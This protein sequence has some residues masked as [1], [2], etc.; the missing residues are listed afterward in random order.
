[1]NS[2]PMGVPP[3][4]QSRLKTERSDHHRRVVLGN[5]YMLAEVEF[6]RAI[7][8]WC[9]AAWLP[10][11]FRRSACSM[12]ESKIRAEKPETALGRQVELSSSPRQSRVLVGHAWWSSGHVGSITSGPHQGGR[13]VERRSGTCSLARGGGELG[14]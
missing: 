4:E 3:I 10:G 11:E 8:L 1:M 5:K 7:W 13:C 6:S 12:I 2:H 14:W 9:C